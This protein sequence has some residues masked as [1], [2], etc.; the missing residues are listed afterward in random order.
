[1]TTPE[2]LRTMLQHLAEM[3]QRPPMEDR[4]GRVRYIRHT[5]LREDT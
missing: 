2:D 5:S 4:L 3:D 1:M